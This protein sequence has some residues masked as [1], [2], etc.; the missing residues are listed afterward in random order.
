MR[1]ALTA[2]LAARGREAVDLVKENDRRG[3]AAR[4]LEE[5]REPLLRLA[6]E[7]RLDVAPLP[8]E[9]A[10]AHARA[11]ASPGQRPRG[12]GLAAARGP[13]QQHAAR[14]HH[15]QRFIHVWVEKRVEDALL[16]RV[17]LR[18]QATHGVPVHRA[19]YLNFLYLGVRIASTLQHEPPR[20]PHARHAARA[21][22]V[23]AAVAAAGGAAGAAARGAGPPPAR[24]SSRAASSCPLRRPSARP[25]QGEQPLRAG[26]SPAGLR[27]HVAVG[28]GGGLLLLG[29]GLH[30]AGSALLGRTWARPCRAHTL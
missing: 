15:T 9:E 28:A 29:A 20:V 4:D 5:R 22:L 13:I 10:H 18:P 1:G 23:A 25:Q 21:V 12:Q 8:R 11:P 6:H 2:R 24:R 14:R 3:A 26:L 7:L 19:V 30:A 27:V 17:Y 16:Q